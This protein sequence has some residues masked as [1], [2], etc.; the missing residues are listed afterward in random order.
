MRQPH[1]LF[2]DIK[3]PLAVV[4]TACWGA[5]AAVECQWAF[6]LSSIRKSL[7]EYRFRAQAVLAWFHVRRNCKLR[8]FFEERI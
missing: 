2:S 5:S 1:T 8:S 6:V 4:A 7:P 3:R